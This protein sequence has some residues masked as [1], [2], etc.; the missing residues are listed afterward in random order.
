MVIRFNYIQ[1]S[2]KAK[3]KAKASLL[4][5]D[6]K[7]KLRLFNMDGGIDHALAETEIDLTAK[8]IYFFRMMIS[9]DK[10]TEN[11]DNTLDMEMFTKEAVLW[12]EE[13][14]GREI[15]FLSAVHTDTDNRH[16]HSILFIARKGRADKPITKEVINELRQA[17]HKTATL[18]QEAQQ[19]LTALVQDFTGGGGSGFAG[20]SR[21]DVCPRCDRETLFDGRCEACG[22]VQRRGLSRSL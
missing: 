11:V 4:Y 18:E 20:I 8:N 6:R 5:N 15:P 21:G 2:Y 13:R 9:P 3:Q 22:Y 17:M 16:T 12:L 10:Q 19:H 14:I 7:E 1:H